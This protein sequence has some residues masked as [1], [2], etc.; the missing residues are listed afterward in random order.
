MI[1]AM[2]GA[3]GNGGGFDGGHDDINDGIRKRLQSI[4]PKH[5]N[6][7][8]Q[9]LTLFSFYQDTG[10]QAEIFPKNKVILKTWPAS[11]FG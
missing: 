3:D 1:N 10:R 8:Y 6:S 11:D 5:M 7:H 9:G 4:G 2:L